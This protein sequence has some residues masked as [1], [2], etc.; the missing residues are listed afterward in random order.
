MIS[1]SKA[2]VLFYI[3]TSSLLSQDLFD[4]YVREALEFIDNGDNENALILLKKA[5]E[6]NPN[7]IGVNSSLGYLY[8]VQNELEQAEMHLI[9]ATQIDPT[10][11]FTYYNLACVNFKWGIKDV[12][13]KYLEQAF[14]SGYR[15]YNWLFKDDD[16]LSIRDDVRFKA[17]LKRYFTKKDLTSINYFIDAHKYYDQEDFPKAAKLYEKSAK[18]EEKTPHVLLSWIAHTYYMAAMSYYKSGLYENSIKSC[19]EAIKYF[20]SLK[21]KESLASLYDMLGWVFNNIG[22]FHEAIEN[23]QMALNYY[24]ELK[25]STEIADIYSSIGGMY[26]DQGL[27]NIERAV[28]NRIFALDLSAQFLIDVAKQNLI[29]YKPL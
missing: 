6:I 25:D 15:E 7:T 26:D 21:D 17:L 24:L 8:L 29:R 2:V 1:P 22:E 4:Q 9:R 19:K 13:L 20:K 11:E 14:E 18:S 12:G 27:N 10:I 3:F 5:Y 28:E 16:L 23:K